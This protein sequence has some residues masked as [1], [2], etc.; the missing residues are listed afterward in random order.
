MQS[1]YD[2]DSTAEII[3]F[4]FWS[5]AVFGLGKAI[6]RSFWAAE[7]RMRIWQSRKVDQARI[8]RTKWELSTG[9]HHSPELERGDQ[10]ASKRPL[11][12]EEQEERLKYM[13]KQ[14][15]QTLWFRIINFFMMCNFCHCFWGSIVMYLFTRQVADWWPGLL[16]TSFAVATLGAIINIVFERYA[17]TA[18]PPRGTPGC[19][20]GSC[21]GR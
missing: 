4:V 11:T 18:G 16:P 9:W 6:F 3:N 12:Q 14:V 10:M 13:D 20:D 1:I 19:P 7:L 8:H 21:G 15:N 5:L 17:T 2:I